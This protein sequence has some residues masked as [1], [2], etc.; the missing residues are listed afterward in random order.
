MATPHQINGPGKGLLLLRHSYTPDRS[1][2]STGRLSTRSCRGLRYHRA[3][4]LGIEALANRL[5]QSEDQTRRLIDALGGV[6]RP[7]IHRGA[8]N[9]LLV[10]QAGLAILERAVELKSQGIRLSELGATVAQEVNGSAL[11]PQEAPAEQREAACDSCTQR[12]RMIDLLERQLEKAERERDE[13]RQ[14]ALP[15]PDRR[16]WWQR[17][18][19]ASRS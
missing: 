7:H 6:L 19:G 15:N 5:G 13:Y 1:D 18:L 8:K 3:T 2:A 11:G 12:D 14:L 4:M 17:L 9:A 10:D 16:P